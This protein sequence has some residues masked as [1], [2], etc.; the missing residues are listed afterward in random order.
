MP[1]HALLAFNRGIVSSKSLA[2]IDVKRMALSAETQTNWMPRALGPMMLRP[3]LAHITST[4]NDAAA[5]Y[6]EFVYS[7]SDMALIELTDSSMRVIIDDV[8]ITRPA[9][10]SK[11]DRWN[12]A[13]WDTS[14][15]TSSLFTNSTDVGYWKDNDEAGCTSAF[16]T[17]GYLSLLGA[18]T[19]SAIRDRRLT[20]VE[21]NVEHSLGIV[22]NRGTV[23]LR[24]GTS[25]GGDELLG[26]RTLR[27]G[28]H[29]ISVTPTT[30]TMFVRLSSGRD[31]ASLV[32]SVTLGQAAAD[33]TL[34]TPWTAAN[35]GNVRWSRINDVTF[36][37]CAGVQQKRI[38]RQGSDSPRSWSVVEY[39]PED[40]PFRDINVGPVR[41]K[42]S[43]LTG[44]ITLTAERNFF[45]STH[46]GGLFSLT[47]AGQ[48]VTAT[49]AA[50]NTFTSYIRV[51]GIGATRAFTIQLSGTLVASTVTLQRSVASPGDWADVT[52]YVATTTTTY[53][54]GLDNQIIYY[55]IGIKTGN[56][57]GADSVGATLTFSAGS[58]T[59][60]VRVTAYTSATSVSAQVLKA[61]GKADQYTQDWREGDWS[62]KNGFPSA[63]A[64]SDGRLFW[65]GKGYAW[66]SVSDA[67]D[68][69][70][71]TIEGDSGPIRRTLGEGA[72]DVVNWLQPSTNLICG[73][74]TTVQAARS[75]SL[76]E[77]LTPTKFNLKA[78]GDVGTAAV[79]AVRIDTSTV[80]VGANE[81][82]VYEVAL[83]ASTYNYAPPGDLTALCPEIGEARFVRRAFQRFPDRRLHLVRADGTAAVLVF[84]KLE[85]VTCWIEVTTDGTIEDAVV[86]PGASG[87]KIEDRVY[88]VVNRTINGA[89]K[90]FLEKWALESQCVGGSDNRIADS[91]LTGTLSGTTSVPVAHLEAKTVCLWGNSKYLGTYTVASGTITASEAITGSYCVGLVY[92]GQYKSGKRAVADWQ[93]IMLAEH[94]KIDALGLVL[95][96]THHLGLQYGPDFTTLDDLPQVVDDTA[97]TTDT[98]HSTLEI[99]PTG[100][101]GEWDT[102]TRLCLQAT[103]P[104]PCTVL[105]VTLVEHGAG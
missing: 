1:V 58:I 13:S 31:V 76:D 15:D 66:G 8:V 28:Y 86:I 95:A 3:G 84:D 46:V 52:N 33:M 69:F 103:A 38:E 60:I 98:V 11:F 5:K 25:E 71:D 51:T 82:R 21:T 73:F 91:H 81:S 34:T 78:V 24:V 30:S 105:G 79:P 74:D 87:T 41:I 85:N 17:G 72:V 49:F 55:R 104:K 89:T 59:G 32:D 61:L 22:V 23:T 68:S 92:T 63:V 80:F 56:Y 57:G 29:S 54:D 45:K 70:D 77:P 27:A 16:A 35:L 50:E 44:D 18:T 7:G 93:R 83:D 19:A 6:I 2:R 96:N 10:T 102:D 40:G 4:Q 42:G 47:S 36:V 67:L 37:A 65:A 12:G 75:S 88:Y 94:K 53:T 39:A 62:D 14:T 43:A 26:D 100:F 101:P 64:D 97:V 48:Q 90:R 20:I 99:D 9:V